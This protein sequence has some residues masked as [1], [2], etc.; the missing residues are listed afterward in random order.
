M[1]ALTFHLYPQYRFFHKS[2]VLYRSYFY[3]RGENVKFQEQNAKEIKQIEE[4]FIYFLLQN[5]EVVYV[6]QTSKGTQRPFSHKDKDFNRVMILYCEKC[7]LDE[8]EDYYIKKYSPAYNKLLNTEMNYSLSKA[9]R[10]LKQT[11]D[12]NF[13]LTR[14]KKI[15][16]RLNINLFEFNSILYMTADDYFKIFNYMNESGEI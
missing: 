10:E 2:A 16:S 14:L 1:T 15:I 8:K 6:G 5:D 13:N 12:E 7:E 4:C 9:K 3:L 11:F